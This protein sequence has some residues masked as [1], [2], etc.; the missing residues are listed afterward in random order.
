MGKVICRIKSHPVPEGFSECGGNVGQIVGM[1]TL[2]TDECIAEAVKDAYVLGKPNYIRAHV[3]GILKSM[4]DH[5]G[6][7]ANGRKIDGYF[8]F[9]PYLKGRIEKITEGVDP[10]RNYV[11]V[12]ARALKE[13]KIDTSGWTF[14]IEGT[15]GNLRIFNISTGESANVVTVGKTIIVTG[16]NVTLSEDDTIDWSV[17]G[18]AKAGTFAVSTMTSDATTITIN[19]TLASL[20]DPAYDGMAIL[21]SFE[22]NGRRATKSAILHV[23][24]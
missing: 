19:D 15:E 1:K 3:E 11:K 10:A 4:I 12:V 16:N 17:P 7:D 21:F 9:I 8:S 20:N 2:G 23:A 6:R 24:G 5:I 14:V 22:I 13:M 18:T